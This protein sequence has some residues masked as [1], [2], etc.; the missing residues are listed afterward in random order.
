LVHPKLSFGRPW[1]RVRV[2]VEFDFERV[3]MVAPA[4]NSCSTLLSLL[5]ET[6]K[7]LILYSLTQLNLII[8]QFW[9][10]ISENLSTIELIF[11]SSKDDKEKSLAAL[12]L[13]KVFWYLGEEQESL[14]F[15]I[16]SGDRF[17]GVIK[18]GNVDE[19]EYKD[20]VLG[21]FMVFESLLREKNVL[22]QELM[23]LAYDAFMYEKNNPDLLHPY[24]SNPPH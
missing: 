11:E 4:L 18:S 24:Q 16:E 17:L 8:P 15:A 12:I 6:D 7:S 13:S 2:F 21:E 22:G 1:S 23:H 5:S 14:K 9:F 10:E 20:G 19:K 3:E